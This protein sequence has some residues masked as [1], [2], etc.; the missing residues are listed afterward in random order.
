MWEYGRL[1]VDAARARPGAGLHVDGPYGDMLQEQSKLPKSAV[2]GK[3]L[4]PAHMLQVWGQGRHHTAADSFLTLRLQACSHN[5]HCHC[6]SHH[7]TNALIK[8]SRARIRHLH[9]PP[10]ISPGLLPTPNPAAPPLHTTPPTPPATERARR[11]APLAGTAGRQCGAL[12]AHTLGAQGA[13][14][15]AARRA[16]CRRRNRPVRLRAAL[17]AGQQR[18]ANSARGQGVMV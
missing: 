10:L 2:P 17:Q 13:D 18:R 6:L 14:R 12:G 15:Q 7:S 16:R 4:H 3:G 11:A 1:G 8:N 9:P 5:P